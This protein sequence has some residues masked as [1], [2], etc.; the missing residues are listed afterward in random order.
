MPE[1]YERR[2]DAFYRENL[3]KGMSRQAAYDAAQARSA[4]IW[5]AQHPDN[6][7]VGHRG[8]NAPAPSRG[9][10]ARLRARRHARNRGARR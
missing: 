1:L 4:S 2:R 5:N 9:P 6:P 3:Q 7:V 10:L 8:R